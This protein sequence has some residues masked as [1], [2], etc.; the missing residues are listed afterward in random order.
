M[1]N[2]HRS[3]QKETNDLSK[4]V[5]YISGYQNLP[6]VESSRSIKTKLASQ[7]NLS[8]NIYT[9]E[10]EKTHD[11]I[12]Q[13]HDN[14]NEV[15]NF[16]YQDEIWCPNFKFVYR[17]NMELMKNKMIQTRMTEES[18]QMVM[19]IMLQVIPQMDRHLE[20]ESKGQ[21]SSQARLLHTN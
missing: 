1:R 21:E 12:N 2:L 20:Q 11:F 4:K 8:V 17:M 14:F 10:E 13:I 6:E 9:Q 3:S 15:I 18:T 16:S 5:A 7:S 19:S